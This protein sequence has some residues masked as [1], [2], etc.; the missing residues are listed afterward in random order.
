M[1]E[2]DADQVLR[3]GFSVH[4]SAIQISGGGGNEGALE[5]IDDSNSNLDGK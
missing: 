3:I 2:R 1:S 4:S 5:K